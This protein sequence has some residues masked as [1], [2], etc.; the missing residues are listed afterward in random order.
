[1]SRLPQLTAA[2]IGRFLRSQGFIEQRQTGSHL[3]FRHPDGR[4]VTVPMHGGKDLGRGL[5]QRILSDAGYSADEYI[6]LS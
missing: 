3:R 1:M 2:E 5:T 4:A 6:L